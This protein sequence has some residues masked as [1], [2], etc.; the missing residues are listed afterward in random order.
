[1]IFYYYNYCSLAQYMFKDIMF[2][3]DIVSCKQ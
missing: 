1:M 3:E 2:V